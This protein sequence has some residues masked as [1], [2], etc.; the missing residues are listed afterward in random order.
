MDGL[1]AGRIVYFVHSEDSAKA[2][3]ADAGNRVRAGDVEPAM[4]VRVWDQSTGG[5]NLKV[6]R[7]G[8]VDQWVTS[9]PYSEEP[10]PRTWHWMYAGQ[11]TRGNAK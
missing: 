5:V 10:K 11:P 3:A 8:P 9:V 2:A 1:V 4:V 6:H 7:D